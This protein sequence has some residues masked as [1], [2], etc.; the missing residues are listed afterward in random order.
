MESSSD[1]L[2]GSN[3]LD[4]FNEKDPLVSFSG[5]A[6]EIFSR[7]L[8]NSSVWTILEAVNVAVSGVA[9]VVAAVAAAVAVAVAAVVVTTRKR[10]SKQRKRSNVGS[11]QPSFIIKQKA[12]IR[13]TNRNVHNIKD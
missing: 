12:H 4:C 6:K 11:K 5:H 13:T 10:F 8:L 1:S 7:L 9:T 3:R 2:H